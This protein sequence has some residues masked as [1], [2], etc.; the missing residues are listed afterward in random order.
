MSKIALNSN[1]SGTGVFTIASPNS[2]TD[3]TLTLPDES[4][5]I[6]S[7]NASGDVAVTGDITS[8]GNAVITTQSPQLGRKSLILNGAMQ[9]AQRGT[10]STGQTTSGYKTCD[11]FLVSIDGFG[12]HTVEQSTDA[13][14]DFKNSLKVTCTTA[15]TNPAS[16]DY[17]F[18]QQRIEGQNLSHINFG[19]S[20]ARQM[21]L[22][23]WVKS[24]KTGTIGQEFQTSGSFER[25]VD[26]TINTANT[27]EYKTVLVPANTANTINETNATGLVCYF[28]LNAGSTYKGTPVSTWGTENSGRAGTLT[29]NIGGAT[30]DYFAIT[31]VQLEV[32]TVATP[33]EHRSYGEELALCQRYYEKSYNQSTALGS[34][35]NYLGAASTTAYNTSLNRPFWNVEM[36]VNKRATPT[37]VLYS[38]LTGAVGKITDSNGDQ[39]GGAAEIGESQFSLYR[40]GNPVANSHYYAHWTADAEL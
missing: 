15:Q 28:W 39:N 5:T 18:I 20:D 3:R 26:V 37:I 13:P 33:F 14:P 25:T 27:W 1:A 6:V 40:T 4:G 9:V 12:T 17:F 2:D 35:S 30:S 21:T 22:S 16:N 31:G 8:N 34:T 38:C 11:R 10:S 19:S 7:E 29:A 36:K 32:G 23:F 24:N